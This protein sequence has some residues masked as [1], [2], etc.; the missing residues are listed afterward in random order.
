[1][2]L[3]LFSL[4]SYA[5]FTHT[6][7]GHFFLPAQPLIKLPFQLDGSTRKSR[8]FCRMGK[9]Y[10]STSLWKSTLPLN[11]CPTPSS[12]LLLISFPRSLVCVFF[13]HG[14]PFSHPPP[15][16]LLF[17]PTHT[18]SFSHFPLALDFSWPNQQ[19][20]SLKLWLAIL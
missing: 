5:Y 12:I 6:T 10:I 18:L 20:S 1:M 13:S 19:P 16:L 9:T 7:P 17:L 3:F 8:D 4:L 11:L 15:L 2:L 14:S